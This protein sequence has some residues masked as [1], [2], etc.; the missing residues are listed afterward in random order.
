MQ[1]SYLNCNPC[2]SVLICYRKGRLSCHFS[3][4]LT[5]QLSRQHHAI[6]I[7]AMHTFAM[8]VVAMDIVA[9]DIMIYDST[10]SLQGSTGSGWY[11]MVLGQYN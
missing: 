2:F 9:M 7:V 5:R 6:D 4:Q 8:Y 10:G 11:L 1:F 3:H